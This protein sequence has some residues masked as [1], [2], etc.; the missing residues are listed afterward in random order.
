[1]NYRHL[2]SLFS[3]PMLDPIMIGAGLLLSVG[4]IAGLANTDMDPST[5]KR[6]VVT[7]KKLDIDNDGLISLEE[8]TSRQNRRFQ[9]LDSND[10]GQ[11][12]ETEFNARLVTMF[13][14]MDINS[15]GMLDDDEF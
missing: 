2:S 10:D 12:D 5:G 14:N 13:K 4:L 8:L 11:I 7:A 9:K 15:D 1:M 3:S 6:D